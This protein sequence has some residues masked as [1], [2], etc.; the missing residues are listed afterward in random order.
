MA[1]IKISALPLVNGALSN[2][3]VVAAVQSGT[4]VKATVAS[5]GYQPDGTN[6][7][8]TTIQA[9]LR[10]T[11]SVKDFGAVGN[12]TIDDTE[13]IQFAITSLASS[14]GTVYFPKGEYKISSTISWSNNN[15][16][17]EGA[18]LGAT[19]IN[20]FI[21]STDVFAI[22]NSSGGGISN[23]NIIANTAQISGAGIHLTNCFNVTITDVIIGYG[24][25][26]GIQI[27]GG[28]AQFTNTVQN[29]IISNCFVGIGIGITGSS[30]QDVFITNG[31]IG[32][33]TN[34][35]VLV[36]QVSGLY[37][38]SLDI[39]SC[40]SGF[41]TFPDISK[42]TSNLF[43]TDV[44]CD[45]CTNYGWSF[46]SNGGIVEQVNISNCWGSTNT[47]DGMIIAV[48]CNAFAI[49]NFRAINNQ[50][51]GIYVQGGTN[52]GF[53]NCQILC[54]S[55]VGS[56]SFDGLAIDGTTTNNISVIG[57]KYGFGWVAAGFNNQ[58][59]GICITSGAINNYSIIGADTTGNVTGGIKDDGLGEVKHIY[60]NPGYVTTKSGS[61]FIA[62]GNNSIT[63]S[64]G[65][66]VTPI[67]ANINLTSNSYMGS[68]PFILDS[69]TIT[70]STFQVKTAT[71]V[72]GNSF[73]S[74]QARVSGA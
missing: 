17:L 73:F 43:F 32:S 14:G 39:I 20:T 11:V 64:H 50:K 7:V 22:T 74:W 37:V 65:L 41:T 45:T 28:V 72:A 31:I 30:P 21:A 3:D 58:K 67:A 6:A 56:A 36:K 9:K 71:A 61:T 69:T 42:N 2:I 44:L 13:A 48:N 15:I 24:L 25:N 29:F 55:M 62:I 51:R 59:Y 53:V 34:S 63:I 33:C 4:T 19:T 8:A 10:E 18:G 54:N 66:S 16:F 70:S 49:T 27:D 57:G 1:N 60:G 35:G 26:F 12:G 40:G 46:L 38:N 68:N 47:F 52:I 23:L 5:F